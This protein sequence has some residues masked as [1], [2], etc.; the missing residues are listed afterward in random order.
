MGMCVAPENK[1]KIMNKNMST[2]GNNTNIQ[3]TAGAPALQIKFN[4][5]V[6]KITYNNLIKNN[7][8]VLETSHE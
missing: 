8:A 6:Q 5:Q 1:N 3:E 4:T 7:I 2:M